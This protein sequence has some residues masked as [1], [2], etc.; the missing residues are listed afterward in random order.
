MTTTG[1][2]TSAPLTFRNRIL[3][4]TFLIQL[5]D[6]EGRETERLEAVLVTA[7]VRVSSERDAD[8]EALRIEGQGNVPPDVLER[9]FG[10]WWQSAREAALTEARFRAAVWR[11]AIIALRMLSQDQFQQELEIWNSA[12]RKVILGDH[13]SSR[14]LKL[15]GS[16][17]L[18]PATKRRLR[19]H[20]ERYRQRRAFLDQRIKFDAPT[21]EP[22]GVL[23]RVPASALNP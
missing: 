12:V 10:T 14:Q 18:P 16:P 17:D 21:V 7:D 9:L 19:Q 3:V 2:L 23:L 11:Q 20:E 13:T 15:F 8:L 6:C 4:A 5:R 22:L 1:W